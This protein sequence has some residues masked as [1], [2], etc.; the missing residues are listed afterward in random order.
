M[1]FPTPIASSSYRYAFAL[2]AVVLALSR[3]PSASAQT[4]T[5]VLIYPKNLATAVDLLQSIQWTS[6]DNVQA[7]YLYVGSTPGAKDLVNS[8]STLQTSYPAANLPPARTLY[9]RVWTCAGEDAR[10]AGS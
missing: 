9:V 5:S 1:R 8:G 2:M 4:L 7:Y 10:R 3:P 6:V